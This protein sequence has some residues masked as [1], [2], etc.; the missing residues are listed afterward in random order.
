MVTWACSLPARPPTRSSRQVIK[1][2]EAVEDLKRQCGIPVST[3]WR[4]MAQHGAQRMA[5]SMAAERQRRWQGM[6]RQRHGNAPAPVAAAY[7]WACCN[8]ETAVTHVL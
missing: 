3:A 8:H 7:D 5:C 4:S 2:I 6:G 1:L